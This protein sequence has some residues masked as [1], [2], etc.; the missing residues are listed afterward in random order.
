MFIYILFSVSNV[1]MKPLNDE[2]EETMMK[3]PTCYV[4]GSPNC[5]VNFLDV[6]QKVPGMPYFPILE[7]HEP[8]GNA[9]PIT[10]GQVYACRLCYQT[11]RMQWKNFEDS[12]TPIVK[13][14][15]WLKREDG[16]PYTGVEIGVQSEYASQL[17]G[18]SPDTAPPAADDRI[19]STEQVSS[20]INSNIPSYV[21]KKPS[22]HVMGN[23][24]GSSS[25][26][27]SRKVLHMSSYSPA[28]VTLSSPLGRKPIHHNFPSTSLLSASKVASTCQPQEEALDLSLDTKTEALDLSFVSINQKKRSREEEIE[29]NHYVEVLDLSMP[30][31]NAITEVCYVC[32]D[33]FSR[34]SLI[35]MSAFKVSNP[36]SPFF[37][38]LTSH[39][40]PSKSR[41][42]ESTGRVQSCG[43]CFEVLKSQWFFF[44]IKGVEHKI[45]DYFF[46]KYKPGFTK[47]TVIC[48]ECACFED[49]AN[50][51]IIFTSN[52]EK[53]FPFDVEKRMNSSEI[54][55]I[56][57]IA[58]IICQSCKSKKY[59]DSSSEASNE[60][61]ICDI[62]SP[63]SKRKRH[64]SPIVR[65]S[66][67]NGDVSYS[68]VMEKTDDYE[69]AASPVTCYLCHHM[70]A[71]KAMNWI[72][73]TAEGA[74]DGMYFPFLKNLEKTCTSI[75]SEDGKVLVCT[76]C[77]SHLENQWREFEAQCIPVEKRSYSHRAPSVGSASPRGT[78]NISPPLNILEN[79]SYDYCKREESFDSQINSLKE[80]EIDISSQGKTS[81]RLPA[82]ISQNPLKIPVNCYLC[83]KFS[84]SGETYIISSVKQA[85]S[86]MHFPFLE[87]HP[88]L[89]KGASLGNHNYLVCTYCFH[90][91]VQQWHRFEK[92]HSPH[93]E[94]F[95]DIYNFICYICSLKTYRKRLHKLHVEVSYGCL[96][97]FN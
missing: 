87:H 4:C 60:I 55:S 80:L 33:H 95:Y 76:L 57:K 12:K 71:R 91:L 43:Y 3:Y 48:F 29:D 54:L 32:G 73:K 44:N 17:F 66:N 94:N 31:R 85:H 26:A 45:R 61:D 81:Y 62:S 6:R 37:P 68:E 9:Q 96:I 2:C 23:I 72:S 1:M 38:S 90:A 88:S 19:Q 24:D 34:G 18:L 16:L 30:D 13:R 58:R 50:A 77:F 51:C 64:D 14:I 20:R 5:A 89:S 59:T 25:V 22:V 53:P 27:P 67:D 82:I 74:A 47:N 8:P 52:T 93:S 11:L 69:N 28:S 39:A 63:E 40:R 36:N 70:Q 49:T 84:K 92:T 86:N 78:P 83:S 42:M 10:N 46:G 21:P 65:V 79:S 7:S 41:P 56:A 75:L 15:Y 35:D 97:L